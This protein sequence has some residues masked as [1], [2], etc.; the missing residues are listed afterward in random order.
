M[1]RC[2]WHEIQEETLPSLLAWQCS[3]CGRKIG[4]TKQQL[5]DVFG[6]SVEKLFEKQPDCLGMQAKKEHEEKYKVQEPCDESKEDGITWEKTK[7]WLDAVKRWTLAGF[8]V[9][10]IE[11]VEDIYN[12]K[13]LVCEEISKGGS[14]KKCGCKVSKSKIAL[15]N[16]IR[17]A[18]EKCPIE[19]W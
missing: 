19:K 5:I 9:R 12:N 10:T 15:I 16:K 4:L 14:C 6:D 1:N 11:E 3:V 17:M 7:Q 13:C 8:P 18:T 2:K